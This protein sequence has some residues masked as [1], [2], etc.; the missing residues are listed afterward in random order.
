MQKCILVLPKG[1]LELQDTLS[2]CVH[3]QREKELRFQSIKGCDNL[4][5][6]YKT[7]WNRK[8]ERKSIRQEC[9]RAGKILWSELR[10]SHMY[11]KETTNVKLCGSG[12]KWYTGR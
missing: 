11:G 4:T 3:N 8:K 7:D 12:N 6:M 9:K 5:R 10:C 2:E 1:K